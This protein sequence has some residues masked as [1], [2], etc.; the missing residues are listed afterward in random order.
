MCKKGKASGFRRQESGKLKIY[1]SQIK[2]N[3]AAIVELTESFV[4]E[5]RSI[6]VEFE[7]KRIELQGTVAKQFNKWKTLLRDLY[8]QEAA[9]DATSTTVNP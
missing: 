8:R 1:L 9:F 7:G 6:V 3:K 4:T 5:S 2:A